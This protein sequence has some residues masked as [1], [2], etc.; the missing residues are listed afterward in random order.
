MENDGEAEMTRS[1]ADGLGLRDAGVG[2]WVRNVPRRPP[3]RQG[4]RPHCRFLDLPDMGGEEW[5]VAAHLRGCDPA[6][7]RLYERFVEL[8]RACGAFEVAVSKTAISFKGTR[9][10]FAGAKPK[11]RWLDGYLDL[12]RQLTD[13]RIRSASPYTKRLFVHQFRVT[14]LDQLDEDFAGWVRE[15]YDVGQGLHLQSA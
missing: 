12:Q 14:A 10:G 13:P 4:G 1:F 15:A 2:E 6:V 8:V 5:T 11:K 9:R 7:I 3:R